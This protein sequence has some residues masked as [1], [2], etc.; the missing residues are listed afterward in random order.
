M[1]I[2]VTG[3]AGFIASNLVPRL[4]RD[5][6]EVLGIDNFS[7]GKRAYVRPLLALAGFTFRELDLLDRPKVCALFRE[8]RPDRVW[9][10]AANSD[11]SYGTLHTDFD[12]KGGTLATYSVLEAMHLA[13]AAEL[14]FSSSGAIYG[15]PT[16]L[17]TPESYGPLFPISLYAASKLACEG[18]ITAFSHNFG[19]RAWLFRFGNIVGPNPTHGVIHDFVIRLSAEPSRLR[20]LGDGRQEKPYLHVDDCIDGMMYGQA[21]ANDLV[22]CFNLA[23]PDQTSVLQIAEH[24]VR[25][26]GLGAVAFDFTGGSRGWKGDVP[27]VRLDTGRMRALGWSPR[28][29]S[30]EAAHRAVKDV[31]AQFREEPGLMVGPTPPAS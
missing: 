20:I 11:I 25:T 7:F 6:H 31:V 10:L 8:F 28:F 9:H 18:L 27:V 2:I 30:L 13:G 4:V 14:V 23:P 22:N 24:I 19:I 12:L 29:S 17:P 16:V 1:R 26:M 5:G 21:H 3:A 15:E